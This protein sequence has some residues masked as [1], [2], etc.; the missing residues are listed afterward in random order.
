MKRALLLLLLAAAPA[1]ARPPNVIVLLTDDQGYGDLSC[2]GN[3]VLET[4][5][6]DR[7]HAQSLRLTDFHVAPMCTPTRGQLLTGRDAARNGAIN[8]SSGRTLLR[9]GLP[10]LADVFAGAGYATAIFGKWHLGDTH[11]YRPQDRGF[12]ES[13]WFPSSHLNSVP[14]TWDN[15]YFDDTYRRGSTPEPVAGYCTDVFFREAIDWMRRQQAHGRPFFLYLPTNAP[16]SPYWLPKPDRE[17]M[18]R[19]LAAVEASGAFRCDLPPDKRRD[20]IAFLAMIRNIDDNVGRLDA[21][22]REA[23]LFDDTLLVFLTDNGSTMGHLYFDAGMR[24]HKTQLWE[25]GHRVPCFLRLPN[26]GFGPPRDIPGLTQVQDLFAT[27]PA[28]C[29]IGDLP[30]HDGLDLTPVLR[31]KAVVPDERTLVI[32]YSRMPFAASYPMADSPSRLSREGAAVLWQHWRLLE[33]RELYDLR[34]DPR[35]TR[36]VIADHPDV[37]KRL[38]AHLETWWDEVGPHANTAEPVVIGHEAE[39]PVLLTACEWL[40]VFVD[41]QRQIRQGERKNGWWEIE[42]SQPGAYT[43]ELRRWPRSLDLPLS[44]GLPATVVTD[45]QLEPGRALPIARARLQIGAGPPQV[46]PL[47]AQA[48]AA[49]FRVQL[50]AGR[51]RLYTWF[52]DA[53]GQP[54]AGAYFVHVTR[55]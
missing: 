4:P 27:L 25:G 29:G 14:D 6:L 24:G 16:H 39:N 23:G 2:H 44:A 28:V 18:T 47:K 8:V 54:I 19:H 53:D 26:G 41:Q 21:F 50:P 38:R 34:S 43:F 12:Q 1:Q 42:V 46:Q 17:A 22:L 9:R 52:D 55:L 45:G 37:A 11:P 49:H 40:D 7:V 48:T 36:N 15:D 10:T 13:L 20:L 32:N 51:S 35:Q 5:H 31:G 33:D 30:A 3:P